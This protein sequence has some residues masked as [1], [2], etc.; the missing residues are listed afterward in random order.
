MLYAWLLYFIFY[1]RGI[2]R[3]SPHSTGQWRFVGHLS[4]TLSLCIK[5]IIT[6]NTNVRIVNHCIAHK[7][8]STHCPCYHHRHRRRPPPPCYLL[9]PL[10]SSFFLC[11]CFCFRPPSNIQHPNI[12]PIK[13]LKNKCRRIAFVHI[14][15]ATCTRIP[16]YLHTRVSICIQCFRSISFPLFFS[17]SI[18]S[19]SLW[20][21]ARF[22]Y[23][24][25]RRCFKVRLDSFV[26]SFVGWFVRWVTLSFTHAK[27][28]MWSKS[29]KR[30]KLIQSENTCVLS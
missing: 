16:I 20:T 4:L 13:R 29:Q 1:I 6:W 9:L 3:N 30:I 27:K 28:K 11:V 23:N 21:N 22:H 24:F 7:H 10:L 5:I 15:F 2:K 26:R 14:K 19:S 8:S 25:S 18:S 17:L 12:W